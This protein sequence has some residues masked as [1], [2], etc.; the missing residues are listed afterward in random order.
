MGGDRRLGVRGAY[1]RDLAPARALR[2]APALEGAMRKLLSSHAVEA[3]LVMAAIT[4]MLE[5]AL[6]GAMMRDVPIWAWFIAPAGVGV[7]A[8][9]WFS[10]L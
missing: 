9:A 6:L 5:M 7:A 8:F 10:K 4:V 3:A 2:H 1:R